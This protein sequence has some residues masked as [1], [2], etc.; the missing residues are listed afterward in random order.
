MLVAG[1][2]HHHGI[3]KA[4]EPPVSAGKA[5]VELVASLR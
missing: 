4:I 5:R 1:I 2:D 3:A